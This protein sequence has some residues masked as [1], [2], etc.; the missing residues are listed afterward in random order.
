V[1]KIKNTFLTDIKLKIQTKKDIDSN[2][3]E[4]TTFEEIIEKYNDETKK[5]I[6]KVDEKFLQIKIVQ[7]ESLDDSIMMTIVDV[8]KTLLY[9]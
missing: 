4:K 6:Y 7:H 5:L 1:P 2:V 8:S 9:Y 3:W